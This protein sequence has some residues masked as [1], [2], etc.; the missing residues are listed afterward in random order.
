MPRLRI[1]RDGAEVETAA[2]AADGRRRWNLGL[3]L[4]DPG[5]YAV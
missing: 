3:G 1:L 4:P 5:L 2:P